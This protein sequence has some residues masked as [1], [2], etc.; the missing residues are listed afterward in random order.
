MSSHYRE[1]DKGSK[2]K[3]EDYSKKIMKSYQRE[4]D[5]IRPEFLKD[6]SWW[7]VNQSASPW[8]WVSAVCG[9]P[10]CDRQQSKKKREP[11]K[12]PPTQ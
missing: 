12:V 11:P 3:E 5:T 1:G 2:Y 6:E 8:Q 4:Y 10:G 9:A 7:Q